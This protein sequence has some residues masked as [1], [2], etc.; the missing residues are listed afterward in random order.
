M[1]QQRQ[2]HQGVGLAMCGG[3]NAIEFNIDVLCGA[4]ISGVTSPQLSMKLHCLNDNNS[5]YTANNV[6]EFGSVV[7]SA[8]L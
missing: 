6:T 4:F 8:H 2:K 3:N 7:R 5:S 1:T